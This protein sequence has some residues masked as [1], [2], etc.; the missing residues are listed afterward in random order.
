MADTTIMRRNNL[1]AI[2]ETIDHLGAATTTDLTA[3]TG[4]SLATISRVTGQLK[5]KGLIEQERKKTADPGRKPEIYR[6]NAAYGSSLYFDLKSGCLQGYLLDFGGKVLARTCLG[7]DASLDTEIFLR[8]VLKQKEQLTR[9]Q[10]TPL[11]VCLTLPG[12]QDRDSGA[13]CRIPNFPAFEGAALQSAME[14]T[15]Q[16]PC[17]IVNTARITAWGHFLARQERVRNLVFLE[18]TADCGIGAGLVLDGKLYEDALGLAGEV[19]DMIVQLDEGNQE[20]LPTEG[21]LEAS[22]G[23]VTIL[24][25]AKNILGAQEPVTLPMLEQLSPDV[26]DILALLQQASRA[27][28]AAIINLSALLSPDKIVVGG[29]ISEDDALIRELIGQQLKTMYHRAIPLSFAPRDCEHHTTGAADMLKRF[30][31]S[32]ELDHIDE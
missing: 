11:A 2:L 3:H 22:S 1:Q 30:L 18:I 14:Q 21:A 23:I 25:K 7:V 24:K 16:L 17:I 27:W 13:V 8:L 20:K 9:G 28:A 4:L 5:T 32:K 15:L 31:F 29:A 12:Q 26:P 10:P 19:G 6:L